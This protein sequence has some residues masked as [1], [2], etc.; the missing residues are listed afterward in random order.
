VSHE[1][2]NGVAFAGDMMMIT[3]RAELRLARIDGE[4]IVFSKNPYGGGAH[5]VIATPSGKFVAA[6][7]RQGYFIGRHVA[8]EFEMTKVKATAVEDYCYEVARLGAVPDGELFMAAA[9]RVGFTTLNIT[10]DLQ[11][12][13]LSRW[14]PRGADV[15][16]VCSL[17]TARHPHAA[18]A[19]G[20]DR[21][22]H[23][24]RNAL[25]A[26]AICIQPHQNTRGKAYK[27]M[28]ANDLLAVQTSKSI[29]IYQELVSRF[30]HDGDFARP[31]PVWEI[32]LEAVDV[33][34]VGGLLLVELPSAIIPVRLDNLASDGAVPRYAIDTNKYEQIVR[35]EF[36]LDAVATT[37]QPELL[38]I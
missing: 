26:D 28:Y 17:W 8:Q 6:L 25:Q 32:P 34:F 20:I 33:Y 10:D 31:L 27:I 35:R 21:S 9:R 19:L 37:R 24:M 1:S 14:S 22:I 3:T 23:L 5:G 11:R 15:I 13:S 29:W 18:A 7:G 38:A 30:L 36:I 16:S 4:R 12:P 2:L